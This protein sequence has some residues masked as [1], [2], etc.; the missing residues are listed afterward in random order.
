MKITDVKVLRANRAVYCK[1][2][3]DEGPTKGSW[4]WARA[5]PGASSKPQPR[6]S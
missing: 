6:P 1:I 5:G 3:T 2:Y 4:V